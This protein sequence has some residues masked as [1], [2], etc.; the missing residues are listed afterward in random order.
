MTGYVNILDKFHI[1]SKPNSRLEKDPKNNKREI[2]KN[3]IKDLNRKYN[4]ILNITKKEKFEFL[5]WW[6]G[7]L[8]NTQHFFWKEQGLIKKYYKEIDKVISK[9]YKQL[10]FRN[11]FI[12]SDHG[13]E[14]LPKYRFHVNNKN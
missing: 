7:K 11:I 10:N 8:D 3:Y 13:M 6:I 5:L 4:Y 1:N 2:L 12:I 14:G 9:L